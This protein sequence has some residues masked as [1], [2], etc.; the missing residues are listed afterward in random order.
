MNIEDS[1]R[2]RTVHV[3]RLTVWASNVGFAM[4]CPGT[5]E[6]P[7]RRDSAPARV[8]F[9][10]IELLVVIAILSLLVSLLMP[11]LRRATELARAAVCMSN[12]K[13][14]A[15]A[16]HVYAAESNGYYGFS[17]WFF[18][19]GSGY[20]AGDRAY[21]QWTKFLAGGSEGSK[22]YYVLSTPYVADPNVF[23]CPSQPPKK[24]EGSW[25]A[26]YGVMDDAR[27]TSKLDSSPDNP[28][29]VVHWYWPTATGGQ[30]DPKWAVRF[31]QMSN[32]ANAAGV[33]L[34]MDS[35]NGPAIED[36]CAQNYYTWYS[37]SN[38][39]TSN[40]AF[41]Q[42]RHVNRANLS[43]WDGHV[44]AADDSRIGDLGFKTWLAGADGEY[45]II[46][47]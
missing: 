27:W 22:N 15:N 46:G 18:I 43:F 9:T 8:G 13:N 6:R 32:A 23:V 2:L 3:L 29:Y 24:W 1:F 10:L 17:R 25:N 38:E 34:H 28:A 30:V 21:L 37:S 16:T 45:R 4:T 19:P 7:V 47:F 40:A 11:S 14:C 5:R 36:G 26:T 12:L 35:R 44:E 42:S 20:A 33:L 31:Y 41:V 39:V